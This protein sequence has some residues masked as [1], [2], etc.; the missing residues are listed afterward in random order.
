MQTLRAFTRS[1]S[2]VM[3]LVILLTTA[4]IAPASAGIVTTGELLSMQSQALDREA[5]TRMLAQ[6]EVKATLVK[7]GVSE[8]VARDRIQRLT[9]SELASFKQ[10]LAE[11]PAGGN[12]VV[13]VIVLFLLIFIV[14]DMLCATDIFTFVHCINK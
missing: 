7:M 14:T 1:I 8:Q 6:Q 3:S 11:A 2:A 5:L 13:G 10:Q 12:T 4:G 9:P